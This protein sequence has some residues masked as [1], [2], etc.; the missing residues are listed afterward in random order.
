MSE[1]LDKKDA[2]IGKRDQRISRLEED[3]SQATE[4]KRKSDEGLQAALLEIDR[5]RGQA[6]GYD[7]FQG[8]LRKTLPHFDPATNWSSEFSGLLDWVVAKE[9]VD[10]N[11]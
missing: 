8:H 10:A 11:E 4:E 9:L 7:P 3:L 2:S 1:S 6:C 5:L